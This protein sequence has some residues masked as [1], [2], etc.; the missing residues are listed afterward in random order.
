MQTLRLLRLKVAK[1]PSPIPVNR[2]D[3]SPSGGGF[4]FDH[5]RAEVGED[6]A[7]D[8]THYDK[9]EF[10]DSKPHSLGGLPPGGWSS[11]ETRSMSNIHSSIVE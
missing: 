3:L 10:D 6:H 4:H 7:A 1:K 11:C 2:R 8:R 9:T 5:I